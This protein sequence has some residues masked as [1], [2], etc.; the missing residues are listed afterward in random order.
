MLL[1][2]IATFRSPFA[3]KFG[4]PR[5]SGLVEDLPGQIVFKDEFCN[6][7]YIRGLEEF[8]Y[9]WI[10]WGFSANSHEAKSPVVR[11]PRLGGNKRMGIFATRSPFRPNAIG[12]SSVRIEGIAYDDKKP[13]IIHVKGA[14]LME[15]TPIYDIKPYVAYSDCHS[16]ARSGF[17]DTNGWTNVEVDFPGELQCYFSAEEL[18]VIIQVLSQDPRPPYQKDPN[19]VYGM[20]IFGCDVRFRVEENTLHIVEVV[21]L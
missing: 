13:T 14:D 19:K 4:I 7:D 18:E 12:L 1:R 17:V 3:S 6:P 16:G 20:T 8:D 5:Q 2:E 21:R 11:P 9:L 10:I 15:G